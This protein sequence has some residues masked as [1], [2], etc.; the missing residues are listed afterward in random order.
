MAFSTTK[1]GV[2]LG[3][4]NNIIAFCDD[5]TTGACFIPLNAI[6]DNTPVFDYNS[7]VGIS[8]D[9]DYNE[10]SRLLSFDFVSTDGNI[11][12]INLTAIKMDQIGNTSACS[13]QL[14]SS[15]GSITCTIP[16]SIGN[17]TLFVDI[18][19]DSQ[20]VIND[21]VKTGSAYNLGDWGYLFLL[22]M[23][24]SFPLMFSSSKAGTIV[25]VILGFV[26][27]SIYGFVQGGVLGLGASIMWLIIAGIILIY[28]LNTKRET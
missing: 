4:F 11:K 15:A 25:G 21:Y 12:T 22:F 17:A 7:S 2:V 14:I 5:Q 13:K 20:L 8:Y 18:Y 27:A 28:S 6:G 9:L 24:L 16:G 1:K 19:A 26:S 10:S 3:T 23:L